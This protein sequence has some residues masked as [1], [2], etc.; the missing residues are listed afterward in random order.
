MGRRWYQNVDVEGARFEDP[1][2]KDS[3][4]WNEGKWN[5][6]IAPLLP[7]E[8]ETFIEIGC[9]AGLFL[10]MATEAGFRNVIGVEGNPRIMAQAEAFKRHANGNWKLIQKAV[11]KDFILSELP[12]ADV[13]LI[14]NTH[15]Y[16]PVGVFSN[17]VDHLK[18]RTLYCLIVSG[19]ARKL[20]GCAFYNLGSVRGYFR[21]WAE[22]KVVEGLDTEGDSAPRRRMY[23]VLFK[24]SL[25]SIDV[26]NVYGV[27]RR[28]ATASDKFK[29]HALPPAL[30]EFFRRTLN[31]EQF[32]PTETLLYQY[33]KTLNYGHGAILAKLEQ[34]RELA[35]SVQSNGMNEPIYYDS[36]G[37]LL[38]GLH[39]LA[40]AKELGCKHILIRRL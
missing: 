11:G 23:S 29:R 37:K 5:N 10:K 34:K 12:L 9:N 6:F 17:L 18:S 38:D 3:K 7:E 20:S 14:S 39:R 24:G 35:E 33:W 2:R 8:R 22:I 13:A 16:F 27:Y 30:E 15:Y 40:I 1:N 4:F 32:E 19:R 26:E 25:D 31:D 28:W 36:Y 21:D